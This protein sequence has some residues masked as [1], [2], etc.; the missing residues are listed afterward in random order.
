MNKMS[1]KHFFV[2]TEWPECPTGV[3]RIRNTVNG[4]LYVGST[5]SATFRRRWR[6]HVMDLRRGNH[7]SPHLQAAWNKYGEDA[8]EFEVLL[9]CPPE[10]CLRLE[11]EC[12]DGFRSAN[13]KCGYNI[14]PVAGSSLGATRSEE[15]RKRCSETAKRIH[16]R[17]EV[18]ELRAQVMN[19]PEYKARHA[20]AMKVAMSKPEYR[21]K[22]S[23]SVKAALADPEVRKKISDG[24]K[25]RLDEDPTIRDRLAAVWLGRK[26]TEETKAKMS[27]SG[28]TP[29]VRAKK[30]AASLGKKMS[31]E[32]KAKISAS[33]RGKVRSAETRA[34]VAA[35][36]QHGR[37]ERVRHMK[38]SR[39]RPEWQVTWAAAME[40]RW[41]R[42]RE[43]HEK[44]TG[45]RLPDLSGRLAEVK[46][47]HAEGK[48]HRQIADHFGLT[49]TIIGKWL[50]DDT[51][52]TNP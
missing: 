46:R 12:I 49:K 47:L 39:Q 3:Y 2:K 44:A 51:K 50:S 34:K 22:M 32:V 25:R 5:A 23:R 52:R 13:P 19:D 9:E 6:Q 36:W 28:S 38:E 37:E 24:V 21:E 7:H 15:V 40:K 33:T 14:N 31:D 30:S 29:E 17:P 41:D 16:A 45:I 35:S 42:H 26:H 27:A 8:F 11:Q 10:D 1:R 48:T 18:K 4:K 20:A 43:L